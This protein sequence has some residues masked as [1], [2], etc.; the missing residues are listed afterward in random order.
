MSENSSST[1]LPNDPAART[2]E[3]ELKAPTAVLGTDPKTPTEPSEKPDPATTKTGDDGKPVLGGKDDKTEKKETE[4][5]AGA[6]EKY[7]D[8]KVPE[9]FELNEEVATEAGALFKELG[10]NQAQ[11]QKAVDFYTA[12]TVEAA[13]APYEAWNATQNEWK[14]AIRKDP[15]IGGKLDEV[16]ASVGKLYDALGDPKLV[17]DFKEAMEFTGAGNNPAFVK[18][19]WKLSQK[20]TEGGPVRGHGPVE[21]RS[22][23][24]AAPSIANAMF[25]NLK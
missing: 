12:K 6:P 9:G 1:P 5:A 14:E 13:K 11:A 17:S 18:A 21:V 25:P 15:E 8:F 22:P 4:A 20:F 2:P 10:L 7:E 3:G 19:L 16:K 24:G 23:T